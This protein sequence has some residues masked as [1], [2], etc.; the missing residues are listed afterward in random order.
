MIDP[1]QERLKVLLLELAKAQRTPGEPDSDW[2]QTFEQLMQT[3]FEADEVRVTD[4]IEATA[5]DRLHEAL[6]ERK[7]RDTE[8]HPNG[9][10]AD[11]IRS[12]FHSLLHPMAVR[13][14][15]IASPGLAGVALLG[16][17]W[18]ALTFKVEV[19]K[20]VAVTGEP[21]ASRLGGK[22]TVAASLQ[23]PLYAGTRIE[24]GDADKAEI[25]LNN[26]TTVAIGFNT[27]LV[28]GQGDDEVHVETGGVWVKVRHDREPERFAVTTPV[29]TAEAM[30]TEFS[31][32]VRAV[33]H[34]ASAEAVEAHLM[35]TRGR[36]AF[37]NKHGGTKVGVMQESFARAG[38]PPTDPTPRRN[39]ALASAD[40][41]LYAIGGNSHGTTSSVAWVEAYDP[42]TDTWT[43]KAPLPVASQQLAA[44]TIKGKIYAVGGSTANH[45]LADLQAYDPATNTWTLK[46]PMPT[47]R[48][49]VAAVVVDDI[50]YVI[51]GGHGFNGRVYHNLIESYDPAT[52]RW[53][54]KAPMPTA[55]SAFGVGVMDGL[56]YTVGGASVTGAPLGTVEVYDP[57]TDTWSARAP[58]PTPRIMPRVG[59]IDGKL[60]AVGG[61]DGSV[62]DGI[63]QAYDPAIDTW[64]TVAP[65]PGGLATDG[66]DGEAEVM[67]GVLYVIGR[68]PPYNT[69]ITVAA[70][71]PSRWTY[72]DGDGLNDA[73]ELGIYRTNPKN[74]DT[75]GDGLSDGM[76]VQ[77]GTNPV[78]RDSDGDGVFDWEDPTP[79]VPGAPGSRIVMALQD[80][81]AE[82]RRLP[83][84][85]FDAKD[86]RAAATLRTA[87]RDELMRAAKK[88][89]AGDR[90]GAIETLRSLHKRING[91]APPPVWMLDGPE[92]ASL[93]TDIQRLIKLL[94]IR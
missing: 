74:A 30:G 18:Y 29:A 26:G 27:V 32:Q 68:L 41:F 88:M 76:E 19:G 83:L 8:T 81:A 57:V 25:R 10:V 38:S 12:A 70:F 51:G 53:T 75:D 34:A 50:L 47:P 54:T 11:A 15:R 87:V 28:A 13:V 4:A 73:E 56:I 77:L 45:A 24:T 90:H 52:D 65:L 62:H 72:F 69:P 17:L 42:A 2:D 63:V 21:R 6:R 85:L 49:G 86:G 89:A 60:Y 23:T 3:R 1:N 67:D 64:T 55:R 59:V 48:T 39:I 22:M 16:L 40:G 46:S 82:V 36:V 91:E 79:L 94:R 31:L 5:L 35:V 9:K 7:A 61:S 44:V 71:R 33:P 66:S 92:K 43:A 20:F 93:A 58:M 78:K 84:S 14:R 80:L 37:F